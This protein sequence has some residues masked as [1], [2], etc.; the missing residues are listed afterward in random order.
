MKGNGILMAA[1]TQ[2]RIAPEG[3]VELVSCNCNGDCSKGWCTCQKNNFPR[4]DLCVC[5]DE[6]QNTDV[7]PPPSAF[8]DNDEDEQLE[9]ADKC[10]EE[11]VKEL[12]KYIQQI[13]EL[14]EYAS[15]LITCLP[16]S[17]SRPFIS[18]NS[19]CYTVKIEKF[20]KKGN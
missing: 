15:S 8:N 19:F 7:P 5:S 12:E 9:E 18:S 3:L 6:F 11:E 13:G 16:C 1:C 14:G 4:T 2:G 17:V 10:I 20:S